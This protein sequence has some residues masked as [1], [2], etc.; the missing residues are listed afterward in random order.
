[1]KREYPPVWLGAALL[2]LAILWR[3]LGAPVSGAE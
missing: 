3:M 2:A 1:M